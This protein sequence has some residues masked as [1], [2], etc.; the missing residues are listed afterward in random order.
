MIRMHN[1]YIAIERK[2]KSGKSNESS[3]LH[4]VESRDTS[5]YIRFLPEGYNGD[6]NI[7]DEVYVGD[8]H[9]QIRINGLDLLIMEEG[10]II[11]I[12]KVENEEQNSSK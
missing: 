11:A 6:L 10:N 1:N 3:F 5:G 2:G 9:Q 12:L 7:N 4:T 8:S